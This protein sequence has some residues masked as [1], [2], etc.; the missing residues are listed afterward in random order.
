MKSLTVL[1]DELQ[2]QLDEAKDQ[3]EMMRG[4]K[5][6]EGVSNMCGPMVDNE[7]QTDEDFSNKPTMQMNHQ[8]SDM[9]QPQMQQMGGSMSGQMNY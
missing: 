5:V 9:G 8:F 6:S 7:A 4:E 3:I 2:R 1:K